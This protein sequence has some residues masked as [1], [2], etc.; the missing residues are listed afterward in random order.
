[1]GTIHPFNMMK[2]II[3]LCLSFVLLSG[4]VKSAAVDTS[5]WQSYQNQYYHFQISY[6]EGTFY[7]FNAYCVNQIPEDALATFTVLN[8]LGETVLSIQ[9]YKNELGMTAVEYGKKAAD[10]NENIRDAGSTTFAGQDAFGFTTDEGF[11]EPG[12]A[13]GVTEDG[14][15]S[16]TYDAAATEIPFVEISETSQVIY[17][18]YGDYFYRIT[19]R[20]DD[21]EVEAMVGSFEFL[22]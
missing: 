16:L 8:T 3:L 21:E 15:M 19:Y 6:P 4:C 1:F 20:A 12:G 11:Y 13:R 14:H 9:P 10:Y 2:K 7:C 18:D 17:V 5:A 22:E